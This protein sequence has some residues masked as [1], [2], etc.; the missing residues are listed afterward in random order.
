MRW[1]YAFA[2][3]G[4]LGTSVKVKTGGVW[5]PPSTDSRCPPRTRRRLQGNPGRLRWSSPERAPRVSFYPPAAASP[6]SCGSLRGPGCRSKRVPVSRSVY[7][8]AIVVL[9]IGAVSIIRFA[10]G[11]LTSL[12]DLATTLSFLTAPALAWLN[13]RA[14]LGSEV[15]SEHRPGRR[16]IAYSWAGIVFSAGFALYYLYLRFIYL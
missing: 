9:G 2:T 13:H 7:W 14:M 11:S 1:T 10:I 3:R 15:P 5:R 12:I 6:T 8:L 4:P 16:M